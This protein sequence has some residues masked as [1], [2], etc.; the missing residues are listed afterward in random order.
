MEMV[1]Q[2]FDAEPVTGEH[3]RA[4]PRVPQ[5]ESEHTSQSLDAVDSIIFIKVKN[6]LDVGFSAKSMPGCFELGAKFLAVAKIEE[7]AKTRIGVG[8]NR[9]I[10]LHDLADAPRRC[11]DLFAQSIPPDSRRLWKLF[12]Q[13]FTGRL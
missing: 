10:A 5:R 8:G 2:R 7:T 13:Q 4:M 9:S 1:E 12:Q 3:K 6:C 11:A